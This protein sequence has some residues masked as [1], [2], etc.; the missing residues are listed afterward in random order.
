MRATCCFS[1]MRT[2]LNKLQSL[3]ISIH[4]LFNLI[5]LYFDLGKFV[6]NIVFSNG[7]T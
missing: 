4:R 3:F 6:E 5:Y 7:E 2:D 1:A